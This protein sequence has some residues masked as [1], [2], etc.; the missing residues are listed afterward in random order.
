MVNW[1]S[2]RAAL[3]KRSL[4]PV[5]VGCDSS[6]IRLE[7]SP[8]ARGSESETPDCNPGGQGATPWRALCLELEP[9]SRAGRVWKARGAPPRAWGATPP[10]SVF[11]P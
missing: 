4:P 1:A 6:S 9:D 5:G 2:A 7:A 3:L 10:G 11:G 8:A